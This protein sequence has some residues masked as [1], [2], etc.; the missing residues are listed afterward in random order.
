MKSVVI[1][2]YGSNEVVQII[3]TPVPVIQTDEVLIRVEAAGV[4]PIDWKIRDGAGKRIG[5][6]LPI[7]LGGEIVGTIEAVGSSVRKFKSGDVVYGMVKTGGFSEYAAAKAEDLSLKP[8]ALTVNEAAAISLG[9]LT[10]WQGLFDQA[11]LGRGQRLLITGASGAVGS[12]AVQF[13]KERGAYVIAVAS[14][15]NQTFVKSLGADEV[16]NYEIEK[17][18][19]IVRDV[20]VVFDTVGGKAFENS[21]ATVRRG[22]VVVTSVSMV[23]GDEFE[24]LGVHAKRV[25][26]KANGTQLDEISGLV[27][28]GKVKARVA[29]VLPLEEIKTAL[30]LSESGH[31]NGKMVLTFGT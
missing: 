23:K 28:A 21:F 10:A 5:L 30:Q 7:A 27:K 6:E 15:R 25:F 19:E 31:A 17:F 12:L 2:E 11:G 13:A 22:G 29:Q 26:C 14:S 9:G 24:K 1:N 8:E 4:N 18:E 16:L 20:D 3:E